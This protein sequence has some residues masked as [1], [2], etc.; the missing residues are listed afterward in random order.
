MT[1]LGW[2]LIAGLAM[3]S[4]ALVGAITTVLPE[5][6]LDRIVMPTV[7]LA[8]GSLLGGAFFHM[9][10]EAIDTLGNR[11]A[12]YVSLVAGFLVFFTLE[13]FL[14]WHHCHRSAASEHRP[15]GHL[16]LL[17]DG[18]HNLIGG[19]AVGGAFIVDTR[20]GI[21]TWLVAAAH[22]IPQEFGDFGILIHSGWPARL[23]LTHRSRT[24]GPT[25]SSLPD[26]ASPTVRPMSDPATWTVTALNSPEHAGNRIHTDEGAREQGFPAALVAG[27]STYAYLTHPLV[28]AW[29]VDWLERG[30]GEVRFRSPV[31]AG[32]AVDCVPSPTAEG[33]RIEARSPDRSPDVLSVLDAARDAGP[34]PPERAGER[35]PDCEVVLT[36]RLGAGYGARIGDRLALYERDGIIHPAVWPAI[37]NDVF[38][39]DLV[40]GSWI[41]TRSRIRHHGLGRDG[42]TV[43]VRATVV[44]RFVRRGERAVADIAIEHEGRPLATIEHEAII[45]LTVTA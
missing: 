23:T 13:Q 5:P 38:A 45:D 20:V 25:P 7:G 42:M 24:C 17:A 41:H 28:D 43:V 44:D 1:T 11:L 34:P 40:R 39:D 2:I 6:T 36:G 35:L 32:D 29:G 9:L 18:L 10:P 14:H 4:L 3:S 15:L 16:I 22:E 26:S 31:F 30:G 19:L 27:V 12:V 33:C 37:A 21:V 8:A